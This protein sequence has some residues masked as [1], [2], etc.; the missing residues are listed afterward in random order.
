[1]AYWEITSE[2]FY[3][4]DF[5]IKTVDTIAQD[6]RKSIDQILNEMLEEYEKMGMSV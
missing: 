1:M 5:L 6:Q 3:S 2:E 4:N